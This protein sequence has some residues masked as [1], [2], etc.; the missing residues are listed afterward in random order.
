MRCA[1]IHLPH[2]HLCSLYAREALT[3]PELLHVH[4]SPSLYVTNN[5]WKEQKFPCCKRY[6]KKKTTGPRASR[7]HPTLAKILR[8]VPR[9]SAG[10]YRVNAPALF[11]AR[12]MKP[13]IKFT[14]MLT[15]DS[16]C[17]KHSFANHWLTDMLYTTAD[18]ART[19]PRNYFSCKVIPR[20]PL[21]IYCVPRG[22]L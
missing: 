15:R 21:N 6:I 11:D 16:F 1:L 20:A 14:R 18:V 12:S 9:R 10:N 7:V 4:A 22:H 19:N 8:N 3:R 13:V 5:E 2:P 17:T